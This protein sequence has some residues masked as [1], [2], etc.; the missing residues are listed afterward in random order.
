[1]LYFGL[2]CTKNGGMSAIQRHIFY[3]SL[4]FGQVCDIRKKVLILASFYICLY[5]INCSFDTGTAC[6]YKKIIYIPAAPFIV[7]IKLIISAALLVYL[8]D[9]FSILYSSRFSSG[10]LVRDTARFL[11][12]L[13]SIGAKMKMLTCLSLLR[14]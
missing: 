13:S 12:T 11:F 8:F 14:I 7:C 2:F 3:L 1:M 6:V 4:L 9:L 10:N 5:Y